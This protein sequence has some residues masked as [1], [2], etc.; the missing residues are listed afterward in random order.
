MYLRKT[1]AVTSSESAATA[2]AAEPALTPVDARLVDALA[3]GAEYADRLVLA[4]ARDTHQA[5]ADRAY[6]LVNRATANSAVLPRAMHDGIATGVYLGVGSVLRAAAVGLRM[7]GRGSPS[8]TPALDTSPQGRFLQS[9]VNGLIGDRLRDVGS[10]MSLSMS[11]R[12]D[13]RSVPVDTFSLAGAFPAATPR[14]VVFLHGLSENEDY[15]SLRRP[16]M[17]GTYG[18][19]LHTALGWTPVYLRYNSGLPVRENGVALSALLDQLLAGWPVEVERLALVG[20]SMGGLVVRAGCSVQSATP[21]AP[22]WTRVLSDVVTLGT[23]HLGADLARGVRRGSG[24]LARAPEMAAFGRILDH[25]SVGVHDLEHGLPDLPPLPGVR[26]RLVSAAVGRD[27]GPLGRIFGDLLVRRPSATG[28]A[29][30]H[31]LFPGAETLHVPRTDHFGLLNHPD[32]C[33]AL[34]TWLV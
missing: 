1:G 18:S 10:P 29:R 19:R 15:W 25:R 33:R 28:R 9:A 22:A 32:V 17:G 34:R 23:P 7:A 4:T 16:E 3:L 27:R 5:W 13:G 26:Y 11:V 12:V 20:H 14:V 2:S 8:F 30:T 6:G 21:G 31:E 24:W